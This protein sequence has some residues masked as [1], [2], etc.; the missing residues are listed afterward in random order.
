[1]RLDTII[2]EI[3]EIV[4]DS[5]F[6]ETKITTMVNDSISE[7]AKGVE[8]P[9]KNSV[10]IPLPDLFAEGQ[11]TLLVDARKI[12]LPDDYHRGL[13]S[14]YDSVLVS[15]I[16]IEISFAKFMQLHPTLLTGDVVDRCC[17]R[18][19]TL[20]YAPSKAV[21]VDVI[22]YRKPAVL[23]DDDDEPEGIPKEF[24]RRLIVNK[25]CKEIFAMIEDGIEGAKVNTNYHNGQ[26]EQGLYALDLFLGDDGEPGYIADDED[27]IQ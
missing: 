26:Y 18:G 10:S 5:D 13:I 6:S 14:V 21:L 8:I 23:V 19:S 1:M 16:P 20:F 12:A 15:N 25:V 17:V 3:E 9:G 22:Y 24:Q 4:Q 7:I 2:A 11:I 27:W